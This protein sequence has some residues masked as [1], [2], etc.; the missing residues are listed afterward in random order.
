MIENLKEL[1]Q[2][3]PNTNI[4]IGLISGKKIIDCSLKEINFNDDNLLIVIN[5]NKDKFFINSKYI[6]Y[7]KI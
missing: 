6:E 2:K 3:H 1:T 5:A 4:E 7:I